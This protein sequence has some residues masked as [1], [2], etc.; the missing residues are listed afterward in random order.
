MPAAWLDLGPVDVE[1]VATRYAV[2]A[3]RAVTCWQERPVTGVGGRNFASACPVWQMAPAGTW[4]NHSRSHSQYGGLLAETG[5]LGL[6]A[7]LLLVWAL[8]RSTR[9]A[10]PLAVAQA[11]LVAYLV[12]AFGGDTWFLFPFAAWLG[13]ALELHTGTE[14]NT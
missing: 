6:L 1:V 9:L 8:V 13:A 2:L 7:V 14:A 3:R 10:A 11:C 5:L 12:A 4:D